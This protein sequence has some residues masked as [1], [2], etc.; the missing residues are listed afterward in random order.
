MNSILKRKVFF[1]QIQFVS[2][3]SISSGAG[4]RTDADVLRDFEGNPFIP[5]SSLA[6]A[7]RAYLKKRNQPC[8]MGYSSSSDLGK[9]SS[10]YI[11]DLIFDENIV[12]GIRDGVKLNENK[13]SVK[14]G[15]YDREIL[16]AKVKGHIYMELVIRQDDNE[17]QMEKELSDVFQGINA[18]EIRLGSRKTRG[19]GVFKITTLL[20]RTYTKDNYL[21]YADVYKKSAWEGQSNELKKWLQGCIWEKRMVHVKVPLRMKGGISIRQYAAKKHE[22]DFIQ[23]MDHG[24]PVIPGSSFAGA[25]RHRIRTILGELEENGVRFPISSDTLIKRAF[26]YVEGSEASVSNIVID[27]A[28]IK[29]GRFLT[30]VRTGISRFESAVKD[31]ALYKE[32]TYVEGCVD[33]EIS[34]RIQENSDDTRWLLGILLL[35]LKDLQNGFLSV[36]GQTAVGRGVFCQNGPILIDGEAGREEKIISEIVSCLT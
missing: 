10:L 29:G 19:F 7:M 30:I 1:I 22:P 6:G 16:E 26:G 14:E 11:S 36:G 2:P 15:K 8:M 9:M 23:L 33:L 32:K 34:V 27:E 4:E 31:T 17:V 18:G 21:E 12:S 5:G 3:L 20:V 13:V 25:I 28:E 24:E 35:A